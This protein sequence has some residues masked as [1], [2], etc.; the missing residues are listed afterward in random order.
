MDSSAKYLIRADI[1]TDGVV[2]R[3][4]VVGAVFGQT[5]G[6][7][8][9]ELDIRGLQESAKLGRIDVDID[10]EGGQSFGTLTIGSNLDRTETAILA[11]ALETIDR[12]GPCSAHIEVTAIEDARA[13]RR[14]AVVDRAKELLATAFEDTLDS[15]DIVEEVKESVR[16]EAIESYEGL[17]AGPNVA[18]SDAVIVVEGRADVL[19]LLEVG[20]KNAVAVEGTD[21]PDAV[22]ELTADRTATAFLDG[23]RGGDLILRE[24]SQVADIDYVARAPPGEAVEELSREAALVALREKEPL[25]AALAELSGDGEEGAAVRGDGEGGVAADAGGPGT[26]QPDPSG[27]GDPEADAGGTAPADDATAEGP[28]GEADGE[29]TPDEDAGPATLA[30]HAAEV[31]DAGTVR[32]LDGEGGVLAEGDADDAFELL[33]AAETAPRAVVLDGTVSQRLLDLAAQRGVARVVGRERGE[34]TKQPAA[35]RVHTAAELQ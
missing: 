30:D 23:D 19:R 25:E 12:V 33:E 15:E 31:A 4:D 11:A 29:P 8:G 14:Q 35:V 32:L 9:E 13:A 16:V 3:S 5:E 18:D 24:L 10:S 17:P 26:P 21:V 34:F 20:V 2:E 28:A 6:L 27:G 22:G 1:V 7:L